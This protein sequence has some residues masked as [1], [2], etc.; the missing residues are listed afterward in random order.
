MLR[1]RFAE[2][3]LSKTRS[4][5]SEIMEGSDVC[6]APV[7]T[8]AESRE[9]PHAAARGSFRELNGALHPQPAPRFSRTPA[10]IRGPEE[11]A[12]GSAEEVL[13]SWGVDP[14]RVEKMREKGIV[15]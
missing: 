1:R 12:A 8:L 4:E 5:W 14:A 13:E 10:Q 11:L 3:F 9:H 6:F 7:L 2:I 15:A